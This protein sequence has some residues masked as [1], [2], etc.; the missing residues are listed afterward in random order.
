MKKIAVILLAVLGI[1]VL[2]A[3]GDKE[4]IT[5]EKFTSYFEENGFEVYDIT[6]E[7]DEEIFAEYFVASNENY[8]VEFV[9]LTSEDY[10]EQA[11]DG[12]ESSYSVKTMSSEVSSGNYRTLSFDSDGKHIMMTRVG[13]TVLFAEVDSKYKDE[14]KKHFDALGYK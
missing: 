4:A 7:W 1:F 2:C 9:V 8:S 6:D 12:N 13:K 14:I 5:S 10:A 3:C 11:L